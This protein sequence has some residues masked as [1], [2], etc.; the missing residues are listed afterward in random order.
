MASVGLGAILGGTIMAYRPT[1]RGLAT[2][3]GISALGFAVC[4]GIASK[5]TTTGTACII[6]GLAGFFMVMSMIGSNTLAQTLVSRHMRGRVLTLFNMASVGMMP[7]GSLLMGSIAKY[8]D[9]R[10]A[11]VTC[12]LCTVAALAAFTIWLPGLRR[13]ARKTEEYQVAVGELAGLP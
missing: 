6:M 3:I 2:H 5:I 13:N 12:A 11:L 9:I 1:I 4:V 8:T 7:M 10:T